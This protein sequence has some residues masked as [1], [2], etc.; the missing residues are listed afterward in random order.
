MGH[1]QW[2]QQSLAELNVL[3]GRDVQSDIEVEAPNFAAIPALPPIAV[4]VAL[5][6]TS[7]PEL[8][9]AE[10]AIRREAARKEV[11]DALVSLEKARR[12]A[13]LPPK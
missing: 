5:A 11:L 12:D 6:V 10:L 3:I 7:R 4:L 1:P 8:R 2:Q 9:Q 13:G